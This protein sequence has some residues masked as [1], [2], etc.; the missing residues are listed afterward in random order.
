MFR[1]REQRIAVVKTLLGLIRH[2]D[3]INEDGLS[4][5]ALAR[6]NKA[7]RGQDLDLSHSGDWIFRLAM[8][9]WELDMLMNF[10]KFYHLDDSNRNIV[11]GL[12]ACFV[13]YKGQDTRIDAWLKAHKYLREPS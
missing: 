4:D 5:E 2:A 11:F 12:L 3:W 13:S 6:V 10:G 7:R 9:F 1:D 8:S